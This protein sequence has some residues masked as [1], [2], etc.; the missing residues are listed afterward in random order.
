MIASASDPDLVAVSG[1]TMYDAAVLEFDFVPA[2]NTVE[3]SYVFT[4]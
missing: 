3:F 2:G 1:K 4:S